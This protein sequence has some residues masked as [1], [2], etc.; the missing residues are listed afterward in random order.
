MVGEKHAL[1]SLPQRR[2]DVDQLPLRT[3]HA[4]LSH[5]GTSI[6]LSPQLCCFRPTR[7]QCLRSTLSL[8]LGSRFDGSIFRV[9]KSVQQFK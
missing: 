6:I 7:R 5:R 8:A 1:E 9:Q 3:L 2:H 4:Y